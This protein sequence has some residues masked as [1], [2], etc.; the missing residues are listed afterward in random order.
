MRRNNSTALRPVDR[1]LP[2]LRGVTK[3]GEGWRADCPNGHRK[4]R[5]S[6]SITEA[7]DGR[8]LLCC[9]NCHDTPGL[10][11]SLGLEVANLYPEQIRDPSPEAR[12][13]AQDAFRRNGWEAALSVLHREIV[14]VLIAC[15]ML[16]RQEPLTDEDAARLELAESRIGQAREVLYGR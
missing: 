3:T 4:S 14:V 11:A 10:L 1:L 13:A 9:F 8:L 2:L 16:R 6:L 15:G 5:G 7:D 12:K